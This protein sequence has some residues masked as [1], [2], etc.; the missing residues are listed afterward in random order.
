MSAHPG[1]QWALE[2]FDLDDAELKRAGFDGLSQTLKL[3]PTDHEGGGSVRVQQWD[4]Q[5]WTLVSNWIKADRDTV[6]PLIDAKAQTYA[7]DHG[8]ALRAIAQ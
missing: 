2:H 7:K 3:T 5:K 4:G 1:P 8:V 6:R